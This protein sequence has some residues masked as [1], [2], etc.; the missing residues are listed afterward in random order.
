MERTLDGDLLLSQGRIS[1][2]L[3]LCGTRGSNW[4]IPEKG[5]L[6]HLNE[7]F[8]EHIFI[9]CLLCIQYGENIG[10]HGPPPNRT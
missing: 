4:M 1:R 7:S 10:E 3:H 8:V 9:Q 2:Q 6:A 5:L